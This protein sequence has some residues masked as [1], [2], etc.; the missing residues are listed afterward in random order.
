MVKDKINYRA[1]GPRTVLTRQTVQGRANDGGLRVGEMERDGIIAHGASYFLKESMLVRGDDYYVAV[2]NNTGAI[3]IYN[4]EK[5]IFLSPFIDGPIKFNE[6]IDHTK[7]IEVISKYGRSFSRIRVPYSF[8]LLI[9][10]LQIMN[11]QM[12]IITDK[13]IDN[14][15]SMNLE[16]SIELYKKLEYITKQDIE[17]NIVVSSDKH[18]KLDTNVDDKDKDKDKGDK[19]DDD[20]DVD[21]AQDDSD[22][23][24]NSGLSQVTIDSI[25]KADKEAKEME[26]D[27]ELEGEDEIVNPIN[28]GSEDIEL[29]GVEDIGPDK[30]VQTPKEDVNKTVVDQEPQQPQEGE[31]VDKKSVTINPVESSSQKLD[32]PDSNILEVDTEV[33]SSVNSDINLDNDSD[34]KQGIKTVKIE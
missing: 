10:E 14:F 8:K 3:A 15:K 19:V 28:I 7:K 23:D 1:R 11:V 26:E 2:C 25:K 24:S 13:N 16:S 6:D 30:Q 34:S 4:R 18:D 31:V 5:N 32:K 29:S 17:N 9:Q 12:H 22:N 20:K 33:K 21:V 27:D